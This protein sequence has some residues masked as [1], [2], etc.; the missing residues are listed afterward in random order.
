MTAAAAAGHQDLDSS[1]LHRRI[2]QGIAGSTSTRGSLTKCATKYKVFLEKLF[3]EQRDNDHTLAEVI[4]ACKGDLV[5]ELQL[6]MMDMKRISARISVAV[7]ES[8]ELDQKLAVV[9]RDIAMETKAV[10]DMQK[11]YPAAKQMRR[12][13]EEYEA[14]AKMAN[15]RESRRVLEGKLEA[16]N[17]E[18]LKTEES[19]KQLNEERAE[20]EAQFQLLI[21]VMLDLKEGLRNTP[22]AAV[23]E[24]EG[25]EQEDGAIPMDTL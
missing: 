8:K 19:Q 20:R 13:K 16:A 25:E 14:L 7:A 10:Q 11:K 18:A 3:S 2:E 21:Q 12:Q 4:E 23:E 22:A 1:T 24:E 6:Y 15:N 5:R 17:V 9:S